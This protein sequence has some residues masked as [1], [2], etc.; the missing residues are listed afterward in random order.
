[1]HGEAIDRNGNRALVENPK[2]IKNWLED[3]TLC[4][5]CTQNNIRR[6]SSKRGRKYAPDILFD[7]YQCQNCELVFIHPQPDTDS[8]KAYYP[9]SYLPH[10]PPQRNEVFPSNRL[11][12]ALRRWV[13]S[14]LNDGPK[15][16]RQM[17]PRFLASLYNRLSYRSLPIPRRE[18]CLLDVGSGVGSYL[19]VVKELGWKAVGV[20]PSVPAA[21]YASSNYGVRIESASFEEFTY[22]EKSFDVITMWHSLEHFSD[23]KNILEKTKGLLKPGGMLM[24]GLP[25]HSSLDRRIFGDFWNGYEIPLHLFHFSPKSIQAMLGQTGFECQTIIHTIR[26]QDALKSM[27]AFL[28]NRLKFQTKGLIKMFL[29]LPAFILSFILS[30]VAPCLFRVL[31]MG[32][33]AFFTFSMFSAI[34]P[35]P[36]LG[37]SGHPGTDQFCANSMKFRRA[38]VSL[39]RRSRARK[40]VR[41]PYSSTH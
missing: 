25:N 21:Q 19:S 38:G 2:P 16:V 9:E 6:L 8:L 11:V 34:F 41:R 30:R 10:N 3:E 15:A 39:L 18:G 35:S 7:L 31:T 12:P 5:G 24:L 37:R 32:R 33:R 20:E 26:P 22:P 27:Q 28:E 17:C 13:F 4:K 29:F 1:M 14:S 40:N 23:P 36:G